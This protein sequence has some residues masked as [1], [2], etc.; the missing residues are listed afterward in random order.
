MFLF[1]EDWQCFFQIIFISTIIL[2]KVVSF[3]I[4]VILTNGN[5]ADVSFSQVV[6]YIFLFTTLDIATL[7]T[8]VCYSHLVINVLPGAVICYTTCLSRVPWPRGKRSL[9]V[10]QLSSPSLG[11]DEMITQTWEP[12]LSGRPSRIEAN[13]WDIQ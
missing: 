5:L 11:D 3:H 6:F 10:L 1:H 2:W 12:V 7:I 9:F 8:V 4:D 13:T